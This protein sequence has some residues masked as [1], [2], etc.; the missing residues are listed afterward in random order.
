MVG[1]ALSRFS[2]PIVSNSDLLLPPQGS[3]DLSLHS[4]WWPGDDC[5]HSCDQNAQVLVP[6]C[7]FLIAGERNCSW[8]TPSSFVPWLPGFCIFK[9]SFS[10]W[11]LVMAPFSLLPKA[12]ALY[13][14]LL[15]PLPCIHRAWYTHRAFTRFWTPWVQGQCL[16]QLWLSTAFNPVPGTW[17]VSPKEFL[18]EWVN[19]W[20]NNWIYND[21]RNWWPL[22]GQE[23]ILLGAQA[24]ICW[25]K[26]RAG[27]MLWWLRV[28]QRGHE[29]R[30]RQETQSWV[31][32]RHLFR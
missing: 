19:N 10:L 4:V 18:N 1:W 12:P 31:K 8:K 30:S 3:W 15:L 32:L 29:N 20:V 21:Q 6:S 23:H 9:Q 11:W 22:V 28:G 2:W 24:S 17:G 13:F 25:P 27:E 7:A 14:C 26:N 5:W 16:I